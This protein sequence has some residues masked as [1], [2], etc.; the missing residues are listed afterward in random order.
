[1]L[2]K[3]VDLFSCFLPWPKQNRVV[4]FS[5]RPGYGGPGTFAMKLKRGFHKQNIRHTYGRLRGAQAALVFGSTRGTWFHKLCKR[6]NIRTVLRVDGFMIPS[7]FDNRGQ[8]D[9]FQDRRLRLCDMAAN[10]RLQRDLL[11]SDF[12]IYQ[13][14]FSKE[15]ADHFLYNRRDRY[16]IIFNG[17]DLDHF[18][19]RPQNKDVV[20]LLCLG[21]LRHEYMLGSILPAFDALLKHQNIELWIIGSMDLICKQQI[22]HYCKVNPEG[23]KRIKVVGYV[24]N[25]ELPSFINQ[26]DILVHPRL[27]DWCPNTVIECM[28]CGVPVVCGSWGGTAELVGEGG[29]V[30]QTNQWAYGQGYING[31][32]QAVEM[33]ICDLDSYKAKAR[34]RAEEVFDIRLV[35]KR[36]AEAMGVS[37]K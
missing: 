35:A 20:R 29:A 11:L 9:R 37:G 4:Y 6:W 34:R 8:S 18:C 28:A 10:Y 21:T 19:I 15:M 23:S 17:V 30:V 1:M 36:Y 16:E 22:M 33:V 26:T 25:D 27:G 7:Y 13:S 14:A 32:V 24:D 12:V 31:L 3:V 5:L 2:R